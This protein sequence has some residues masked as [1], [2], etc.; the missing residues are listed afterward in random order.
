MPCGGVI[1]VVDTGLVQVRSIASSSINGT[2]DDAR[3]TFWYPSLGFFGSLS[4][5]CLRSQDVIS[6]FIQEGGGSAFIELPELSVRILAA[7]LASFRALH[8]NSNCPS[9]AFLLHSVWFVLTY[10]FWCLIFTGDRCLE[11]TC[12]KD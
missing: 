1:F 4:S 11:G 8:F 12:R 2:G 9:F 10:S 7:C 5:T 6:Y 3:N